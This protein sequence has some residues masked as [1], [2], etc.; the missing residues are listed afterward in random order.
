MVKILDNL[1]NKLQLLPSIGQKTAQR[2]A[3]YI[4]TKLKEEQVEELAQ[5]ILEAK[6]KLKFCKECFNYTE[7]ELCAICSNPERDRGI[8]CVVEN[9]SDVLSIE[10]SGKYRGLYHVLGGALSPIN[11]I[12][13]ADLHIKELIER[14]KKTNYQEI[15]IATN[16][17]REG[18][19]T[20]DYLV[21]LIKPLGIKVTR[22]A[23]GLPIGSDLDLADS[24][25]ISEAL[26][27][28]REIE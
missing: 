18:E 4:L 23:R 6:R 20:A 14:I 9:P 24:S 3:F 8:L 16:P 11:N 28:R 17:T 2:I 19:A 22:I 21:K 15:I 5:A 26:E 27:G 7:E 1:I 12:G 25:T 10:R 13:P